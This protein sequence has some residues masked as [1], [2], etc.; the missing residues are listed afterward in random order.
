MVIFHHR[1]KKK[2]WNVLLLRGSEELV[3]HKATLD[4][5]IGRMLDVPEGRLVVGVYYRLPD[6]GRPID[7]AFSLQL[8]ETS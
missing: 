7:E 3:K 5:P 8:K 6:Q 1:R 4:S 2:D